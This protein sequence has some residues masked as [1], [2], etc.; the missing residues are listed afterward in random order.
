MPQANN[1][2][3]SHVDRFDMVDEEPLD[4]DVDIE[5]YELDYPEVPFEH[6]LDAIQEDALAPQDLLGFS[7]MT[8]KQIHQ[9]RAVWN[10]LEE[11]KRVTIA[12]VALMVAR[13]HRFS[14]FGRF[15]FTLLTDGSV[16]VRLNAANGAGLSEVAELIRPLSDLAANDENIDVREA[17]IDSLA[18]H[19][20]ALEMGIISDPKDHESMMR[21][22]DWAVDESQPSAIRA[23]ALH[24]YSHNLMDDDVDEIITSFVEQDDDTL[25]LGAMKAM[26]VYGAGKF[27]RFL[28][29]QLQSKDVDVREAAAQA[30]AESGDEAVV[31]MLTMTA[32][33]DKESIVREAAYV[34]L[35][36]IATDPALTSLIELRKNASDDDADALDLAIQYIS[37]LNDLE[38]DIQELEAQAAEDADY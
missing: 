17:A 6:S 20:V 34:A 33:T 24:T 32:R 11:E 4:D 27:T 2:D 5:S 21:L 30:M 19:M 28:E 35:A 31:P 7:N 12:E 18:P 25:Q 10:D 16:D 13:E 8:R 29:K 9:L 36:N 26:S 1:N 23:A 15:F 38:A 22:K 14:D 3:Q 37:E